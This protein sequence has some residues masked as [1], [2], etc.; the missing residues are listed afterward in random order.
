MPS[1]L[2]AFLADHAPEP[3]PVAVGDHVHAFGLPVDAG[4]GPGDRSTLY[5]GH[6]ERVLAHSRRAREEAIKAGHWSNEQQV[7]FELE[8]A[9]QI[10]EMMERLHRD[11]ADRRPASK[12]N[13]AEDEKACQL[14]V[15]GMTPGRCRP[16]QRV[17]GLHPRRALAAAGRS[18]GTLVSHPACGKRLPVPKTPR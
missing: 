15:G 18:G 2:A 7:L 4:P 8:Q 12:L 3:D 10:E 1:E 9:G 5:E 14:V 13:P 11:G 16:V 6:E 17:T